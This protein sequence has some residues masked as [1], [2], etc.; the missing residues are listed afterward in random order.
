MD[1]VSASDITVY[2]AIFGDYDILRD[3]QNYNPDC[4]YACFTDSQQDSDIWQVVMQQRLMPTS[5]RDARLRK[6]LGHA[7]INTKYSIW[8]DGNLQ[9]L[10]DPVKIVTQYLAVYDIA[11][12]AHCERDC[13][14]QE[15]ATN[16]LM[17]KAP[18]EDVRRQV[19]RYK[20]EGY[21]EHN[22]MAETSILIRRHTPKVI[23]FSRLWWIEIMRET[24]RD[25]LSFDYVCWKM[26]MQYEAIEGNFRYGGCPWLCYTV[27]HRRR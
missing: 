26:G 14:Y 22:G 5:V 7:L 12:F 18:A 3:P 27:G 23:K 16:V 24:A 1:S 4:R 6:I 10:I 21:P 19:D 20:S 11:L 25:Q 2:T 13:V 17:H 8:L 15:A 9:L